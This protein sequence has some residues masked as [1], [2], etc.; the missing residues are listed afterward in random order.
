MAFA[1][2][3]H[4]AGRGRQL[5]HY[6]ARQRRHGC[7]DRTRRA[8]LQPPGRSRPCSPRSAGW[9]VPRR[10]RPRAPSVTSSRGRCRLRHA[11]A[12]AARKLSHTIPAKRPLTGSSPA[13]AVSDLQSRTS[14]PAVLDAQAGAAARARPE[15]REQAGRPVLRAF[16][17]SA[18]RLLPQLETAAPAWRQ[19]P[20]VPRGAHA[21][22]PPAS[23]GA[24]TL[25]QHC[26]AVET[27]IREERPDDLEAPLTAAGRTGLGARPSARC[28][29]HERAA[30]LHRRRPARAAEGAA[31]RRRRGQPAADLDRCASAVSTSP[32]PPAASRRCAPS[33]SGCPTWWCSM[34]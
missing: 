16:E 7:V 1:R 34:H 14:A 2:W 3:L 11:L 18:L 26:A 29:T 25:S 32:K 9:S 30:D 13:S 12:G 4:H 8:C 33:P 22:P 5:G 20:A 27:L 6:A 17:T 15:G 24:L 10:W 23:I 31:G 19:A 21:R 28:S